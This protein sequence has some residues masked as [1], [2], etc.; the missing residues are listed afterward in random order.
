VGDIVL[1][2]SD[3]V[4]DNLDPEHLGLSPSKLMIPAKVNICGCGGCGGG[5]WGGGSRC[6]FVCTLCIHSVRMCAHEV[7]SAC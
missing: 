6:V 1:L 2:C 3:G 7:V 4:H 5:G